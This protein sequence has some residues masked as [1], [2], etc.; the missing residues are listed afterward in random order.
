MSKLRFAVKINLPFHYILKGKVF[1]MNFS[2]FTNCGQIDPKLKQNLWFLNKIQIPSV[3][4]TSCR[5]VNSETINPF[6]KAKSVVKFEINF[7]FSPQ[8]ETSRP[9]FNY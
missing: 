7:Y 8:K 4:C 1:L 6:G 2:Y 3:I 9:I 5:K